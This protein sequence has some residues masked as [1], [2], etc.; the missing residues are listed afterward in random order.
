MT[1][2]ERAVEDLGSKLLMI[3]DVLQSIEARLEVQQGEPKH[4]A[5]RTD[6]LLPAAALGLGDDTP[7]D[8]VEKLRVIPRV[9][10]KINFSIRPGCW[11]YEGVI[12]QGQM[13]IYHPKTSKKVTLRRYLYEYLIGP[14]RDDFKTQKPECHERCVHPHH[15]KIPS[16][17]R[18]DYVTPQ[19]SQSDFMTFMTRM[20]KQ[21]QGDLWERGQ[22]Y[23]AYP[24]AHWQII[25]DLQNGMHVGPSRFQN[26]LDLYKMYHHLDP[27]V[28]TAHRDPVIQTDAEWMNEAVGPVKNVVKGHDPNWAKK[29]LEDEPIPE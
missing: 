15:L 29:Y 13:L 25:F 27:V 16:Q 10:A 11:I 8:W 2:I 26:Y 21:R 9:L 28:S 12:T 14:L 3:Y 22:K 6:L 18:A 23:H 4:R 19:E 17:G 5:G 24:A 1:D 20:E 7:P